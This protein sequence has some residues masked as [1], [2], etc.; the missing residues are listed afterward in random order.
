MKSAFVSPCIHRFAIG[1]QAF[2]AS[3]LVEFS[4]NQPPQVRPQF[5]A[6]CSVANYPAPQREIPLR[7][8]MTR[9]H[10]IRPRGPGTH[11]KIMIYQLGAYRPDGCN[12]PE[13]VTKMNAWGPAGCREHLREIIE[14][15][16][17]ARSKIDWDKLFEMLKKALALGLPV[18]IKG[19][20]R[21]AI[22]RAELPHP[23]A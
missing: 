14:H 12:C 13:W 1:A 15:L 16:Q 2:C 17:E 5:C 3:T 18:T 11:L 23:S 4:A 7:S 10:T 6:T 8:P 19:L 20:I 9:Q 21:E 22:R